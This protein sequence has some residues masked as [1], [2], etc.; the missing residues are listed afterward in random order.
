GLALEHLRGLAGRA[1]DL[2]EADARAYGALNALWKLA[3]DDP[4]RVAEWRGAVDAAIAAPRDILATAVEILDQLDVLRGNTSRMLRSDLAIGAVLAEAAA[5]AAV[6]NVRINLPLLTDEA[7]AEALEAET[8][9][10]LDDV[11]RRV[12]D[13]ETACRS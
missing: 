9:A 1:L 7:A 11:G 10:A 8:A 4:K 5:R 12:R 13:L 6:W 3:D 2:A